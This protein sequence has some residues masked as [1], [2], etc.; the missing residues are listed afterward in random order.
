MAC[1]N[2]VP[3]RFGD[4]TAN[5]KKEII[6]KWK[7]DQTEYDS[8]LPCGKCEPCIA[9]KRAEWGIRI[10]HES[11][12]HER[13]CFL[14][15]TYDEDHLPEDCKIDKDHV[16]QFIRKAREDKP[17]RYFAC[18]EYGEKYGRP[19]YHICLFGEDYRAMSWRIG[20]DGM[21]CNN[22]LEEIWN[23]GQITAAPLTPGSAMY[24]AGYVQKKINDSDTFNLMSRSPPIGKPWLLDNLHRLG[25]RDTITINGKEHPLPRK[26]YEWAPEHLQ[27]IKASYQPINRTTGE[28]RSREQNFIARRRLLTKPEKIK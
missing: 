15:L 8:L 1:T 10:Y 7:G 4:T 28:M 18:G 22:F 2:P 20:N 13:N 12:T 17:I 9:M 21:Y 23:K 11:L 24:T 6:F 14:T 5:G 3:V 26:Y 16:R 19:H 25:N 27:H